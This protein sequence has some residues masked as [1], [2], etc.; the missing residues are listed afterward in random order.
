MEAEVHAA[1]VSAINTAFTEVYPQSKI[2]FDNNP[3]DWNNA[4][5]LFA[6]VEIDFNNGEQVN[7]SVTPSTRLYGYVYVSV[8]ARTGTGNQEALQ[9]L[10]LFLRELKY[11]RIGTAN[12][13]EPKPDGTSSPKG[14]HVRHLKVEFHTDP[15]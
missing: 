8:H 11:A 13:Q 1:L 15:S 12:L 4:P 3:F 6:E 5:P 14:W 9:M 2:V 10:D 7:L